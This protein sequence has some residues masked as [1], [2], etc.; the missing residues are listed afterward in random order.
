MIVILEYIKIVH[1]NCVN[2]ILAPTVISV[3]LVLHGCILCTGLRFL[4]EMLP[5]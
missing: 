3:G 4:I 1:G 2:V 5:A